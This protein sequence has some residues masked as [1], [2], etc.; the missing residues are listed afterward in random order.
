[1]TGCGFDNLGWIP[2]RDKDFPRYHHV[3][4]GTGIHKA[5]CRVGT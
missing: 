5:S 4:T 1:V 3:Q 2:D